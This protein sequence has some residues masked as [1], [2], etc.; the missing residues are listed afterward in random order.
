[1]PPGRG[2]PKKSASKATKAKPIRVS[3]FVDESVKAKIDSVALIRGQTTSQVLVSGFAAL[4]KQLPQK[5]REVLDDIEQRRVLYQTLHK[6]GLTK[7]SPST[8]QLAAESKSAIESKGKPPTYEQ[9]DLEAEPYDPQYF[10]EHEA[11]VR[12]QQ[13]T[14][15]NPVQTDDPPVDEPEFSDS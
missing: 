12:E 1:M 13:K 6:S 9:H 7:K 2:K 5:D 4:I 11:E 14:K 15:T 3:I 10:A 8:E